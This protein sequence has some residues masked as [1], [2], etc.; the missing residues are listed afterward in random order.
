M[1]SGSSWIKRE[2]TN[3]DGSY[4]VEVPETKEGKINLMTEKSLE[5][6]KKNHRYAA[7]ALKRELEFAKEI[8]VIE[9]LRNP[10]D[11]IELFDPKED[12]VV[13]VKR[14]D[15]PLGGE[16][17]SATEFES[18]GIRTIMNY[19]MFCTVIQPDFYK[20]NTSVTWYTRG[21][22]ETLDNVFERELIDF[23]TGLL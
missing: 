4:S 22:C 16:F 2:L 11:F 3:A 7:I 6:L 15:N 20:R 14:Y 9:G 12:I 17:C 18:A 23:I 5:F 10:V 13:Y 8:P 21:T 19:V 1:V